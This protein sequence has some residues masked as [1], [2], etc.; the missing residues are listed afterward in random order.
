MSTHIDVKEIERKSFRYTE[1]DGLMEI[2]M[3]LLFIGVGVAFDTPFTIF[4]IF[5]AVFLFP[6]FIVFLRKR[7]SY[8]RTGYAKL[9]QD[10]PK[11]TGKGM[12]IYIL[13]VAT[14]FVICLFLFGDLTDPAL[15]RKWAPTFFGVVLLGPFNYLYS[16]SGSSHYW[17]Y[18]VV[19][20]GLGLL[21]SIMNF[22]WYYGIINW[23]LSIGVFFLIAGLII[24]VLFLRKYPRSAE[25][26]TNGEK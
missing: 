14:A 21:F 4:V 2:M 9:P 10:D 24:F 12:L 16:K 26:V 1:Q 17:I 11:K 6:R 5:I 23:M 18:A 15:Y 3:G 20:L 25:E 8:P 19:I 22:E 13:G 7:L